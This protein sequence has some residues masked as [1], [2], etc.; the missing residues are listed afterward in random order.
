ERKAAED[1][2][3][4]LSRVLDTDDLVAGD[5][6]FFAAT[7][8]TDGDLL[9]GVRYLDDG[10]ATTESLVMRSRSGTIRR[11]RAPPNPPTRRGGVGGP[12]VTGA[13]APRARSGGGAARRHPPPPG[14]ALVPFCPGRREWTPPPASSVRL[15]A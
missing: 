12:A 13:G 5:D 11:V 9:A 4:D 6:V 2:G 15:I 3:Y 10:H 8:V 14:G 1:A 7:G